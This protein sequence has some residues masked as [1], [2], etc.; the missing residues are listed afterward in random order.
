M[1]RLLPLALK[2]HNKYNSAIFKTDAL[3]LRVGHP[4]CNAPTPPQA[5]QFASQ[6]HATVSKSRQWLLRLGD[7]WIQVVSVA[8][9]LATWLREIR[10]G[11]LQ[12][13]SLPL[14]WMSL[15]VYAVLK[16]SS[17]A[18]SSYGKGPPAL[19]STKL[20]CAVGRHYV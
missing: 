12:M 16:S 8:Q 11:I 15:R 13:D 6:R 17:V 10:E 4:L 14:T 5:T 1:W 2:C 9:P 7:V 3:A 18:M 19:D 20:V